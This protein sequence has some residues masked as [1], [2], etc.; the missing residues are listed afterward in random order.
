MLFAW[1]ILGNVLCEIPNVHQAP[2]AV[3]ALLEPGGYNILPVHRG[4]GPIMRCFRDGSVSFDKEN[5][6]WQ[7]IKLHSQLGPHL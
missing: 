6:R 4:R 7:Q 5:R 2:A 3:D 1:I